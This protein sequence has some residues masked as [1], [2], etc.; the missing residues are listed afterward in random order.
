M[1][2]NKHDTL[3]N[4]IKDARQRS[5][6]TMEELAERVQVTPRYL[7]RIENEGKKPSYEILF[8]LIR[9]L[10]ISHDLI[11]Y[12]VKQT[13][14]SEMEDLIHQLYNCDARSLEVIKATAAALIQSNK[15]EK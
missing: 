8:A 13:E 2:H 10:S 7:Y 15:H 1:V 9:E 14:N 4:V 12:P 11:F 3:G 5:N 6:L